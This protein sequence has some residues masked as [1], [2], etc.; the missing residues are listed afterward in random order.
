MRK[1]LA[2]AAALALCVTMAFS[3]GGCGMFSG[4]TVDD[5]ISDVAGMGNGTEG[6]TVSSE[7]ESAGETSG[8]E[9]KVEALSRKLLLGLFA[10]ASAKNVEATVSEPGITDI[11]DA[12]NSG[13]IYL[14]DEQEEKLIENGFVVSDSGSKEFYKLYETNRYSNMANFVTVD[15]MMHAYHMYFAYLLKNTERN[16]LEEEVFELSQNMLDASRAQY[17]KLTGT[18]WESSARRNVEFFT[19]GVALQNENV[20]IETYAADVVNA[21]LDR[22]ISADSVDIS[23]I[24]G[25]FIDYSQF[26]PRGYYEGD[27]GLEKYFRTMMWYGQIGFV[28][29]D[30]ELD[31]SAL[32][33]NLALND[34][35]IEIW[36]KIYSVTSFFAG[37]SDDLT[38]YEI[39]PAIWEA[40]G[41]DVNVD[42][43]AGDETAW[44][45]FRRYIDLMPAPAINSIP[46]MDD[47]DLNTHA[48]LENKGFRFMGQR[49]SIDEAIFQ[50][51]I[52]DYVGENPQG[53][54]RMLPDVLD[55]AA[56]LGS[57]LSDN[58]ELF[59][60]HLCKRRCLE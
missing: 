37:A 2:K 60:L 16:Y 10:E 9:G 3:V 12:V 27:A 32:L 28:H 34:G 46:V 17:D 24:M 29:T 25:T 49:F 53:D 45:S 40:Y 55:V 22:I 54:K 19:V 11:D 43:I 5:I 33:I 38:Y 39:M 8:G 7:S 21:E 1:Y 18:E 58:I 6:Q 42:S 57:D 20:E 51:L 56:A 15:S 23:E 4:K 36:E 50:Q 14:D 47:G 13:A 35:N 41:E 52:Y 48:N 30:E 31:R 26:K 44:E 59:L